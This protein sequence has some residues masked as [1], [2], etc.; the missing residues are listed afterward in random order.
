MQFGMAGCL[1]DTCNQVFITSVLSLLV[2]RCIFLTKA[3]ILWECHSVSRAISILCPRAWVPRRKL[4][5]SLHIYWTARALL[6]VKWAYVP[7]LLKSFTKYL[8]SVGF[9]C[10]RQVSLSTNT[11][12]HQMLYLCCIT[13]CFV[14]W[15]EYS[16]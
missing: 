4:H 2:D 13:K 1:A 10:Y 3:W 12:C 5:S 6:K 11:F 8:I 7:S 9:L 15:N 16:V 14:S